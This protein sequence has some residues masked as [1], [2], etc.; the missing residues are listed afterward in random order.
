MFRF[1]K[2]ENLDSVFL[3]LENERVLTVD[4][5]QRLVA[6]TF[7]AYPNQLNTTEIFH[8]HNNDDE[9]ISL[10]SKHNGLFVGL[11]ADLLVVSCNESIRG[12]RREKFQ[13]ECFSHW[14]ANFDGLGDC[15]VFTL[16]SI[17]TNKLVTVD[18]NGVESEGNGL[19]RVSD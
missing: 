17:S 6:G 11:D 2:P 9:T 12:H 19:L 14:C 13:I 8:I 1:E 15:K 4:S 10:K 16:R 7:Y 3:A 5:H 18:L